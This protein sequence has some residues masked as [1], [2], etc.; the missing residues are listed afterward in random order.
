MNRE[1]P[2]ILPVASRPVKLSLGRH[3]LSRGLILTWTLPT[4]APK[5]RT[6]RAGVSGVFRELYESAEIVISMH[7]S[8][9][10]IDRSWHVWARMRSAKFEDFGRATHLR[11]RYRA[12]AQK[13]RARCAKSL[14]TNSRCDRCRQTRSTRPHAARPCGRSAFPQFRLPRRMPASFFAVP[15]E[16]QRPRRRILPCAGAKRSSRP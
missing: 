3:L 4:R 15:H 8:L 6:C 7:Q 14:A 12:L 16:P 9:R 2:L 1:P 13:Y 11:P 10:K 5:L